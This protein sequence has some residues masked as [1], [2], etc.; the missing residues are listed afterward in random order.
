MGST[1]AGFKAVADTLPHTPEETIKRCR[2]TILHRL[3][4]DAAD[5]VL[6]ALGLQ[7]DPATIR[8]TEADGRAKRSTLRARA[9]PRPDAIPAGPA[10]RVIH[11]AIE[12]GS[13]FRRLE[14]L[15]GVRSDHL[16]KIRAGTIPTILPITHRKII[17]ALG[18]DGDT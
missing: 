14:R 2:A 10:A 1:K 8:E 4:P 5:D 18:G 6:K 17:D 16:A 11:E 7:P 9:R 12:A 3:D 15:T 13:S